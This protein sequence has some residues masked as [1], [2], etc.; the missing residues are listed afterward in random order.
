MHQ[1]LPG[2]DP[3]VPALD[4]TSMDMSREGQDSPVLSGF[5]ATLDD[6]DRLEGRDVAMEAIA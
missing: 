2:S 5:D 6:L 1:H 4:L 3:R